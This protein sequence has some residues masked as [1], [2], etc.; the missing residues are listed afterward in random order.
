M[1][2]PCGG[3]YPSPHRSDPGISLA[4]RAQARFEEDYPASVTGSLI[5][6]TGSRGERHGASVAGRARSD[7]ALTPP[8]PLAQG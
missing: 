8:I 5:M 4:M 1:M 7:T 6:K 3:T 2:S